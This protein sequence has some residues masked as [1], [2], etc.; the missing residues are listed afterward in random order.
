MEHQITPQNRLLNLPLWIQRLYWAISFC[1]LFGWFD[2]CLYLVMLNNFFQL[3]VLWSLC[4]FEFPAWISYR[5][6]SLRTCCITGLCVKFNNFLFDLKAVGYGG[7]LDQILSNMMKK[8]YFTFDHFQILFQSNVHVYLIKKA[9][10]STLWFIG[11]IC[12]HFVALLNLN[13]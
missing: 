4:F 3:S 13:H 12:C 6:C 11:C 7:F 10:L 8:Y 9:P 5:C 1:H 2:W